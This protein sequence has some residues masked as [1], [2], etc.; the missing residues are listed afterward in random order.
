VVVPLVVQVVLVDVGE[1]L[2]PQV[3]GPSRNATH[4]I[5]GRACPRGELLVSV[6]EG[7]RRQ[8]DLL[9]IVSANHAVGRLAHLQYGRHHQP[10]QHGNNGNDHQKLDQRETAA[11]ERN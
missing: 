10:D 3:G 4:I 7:M 5:H 1:Q 11:A 2:D 8:G 9:E 6:V